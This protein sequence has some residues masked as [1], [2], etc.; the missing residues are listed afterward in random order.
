M[1]QLGERA[2]SILTVQ[3]WAAAGHLW[4][5]LD[6]TD[7]PLVPELVRTLGPD[8]AVS[9]YRGRAEEDLVAI[10]PFL[11]QLDPPTFQTITERLWAEPWGV[12]AVATATLD[13]LRFHFRRFLVVESPEG[14]D[15]YFRFYDPRVLPTF[16]ATTTDAERTEFF[17]PVSAFGVTDSESY[18]VRVLTPHPEPAYAPRPQA[19]VFRRPGTGTSAA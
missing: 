2:A 1:A 14:D 18:G 8:R 15:W 7:A 10:A 17:G 16:L 19:V 12:L 9:L 13:E 5:I 6:A 3:R 4:A 11:V